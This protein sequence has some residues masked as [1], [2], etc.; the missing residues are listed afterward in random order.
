[1]VVEVAA[2]HPV[3]KRGLR[4]SSCITAA[5]NLPYSWYVSNGFGNLR[6]YI[7]MCSELQHLLELIIVHVHDGGH[8]QVMVFM[9]VGRSG[10]GA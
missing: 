3:H 5:I 9:M 7:F 2:L 8:V 10:G 6:K 1:M 4:S